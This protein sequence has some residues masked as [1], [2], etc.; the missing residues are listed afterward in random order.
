M[1][2]V[3]FYILGGAARAAPQ[4]VACRLAEKAWLMGH[5]VFIATG[6]EAMTRQLDDL[7]W[8]YR[9]DSF[10]PHGTYPGQS[11]DE[12]PI[13]IGDRDA[14]PHAEVLIN[15]SD[16][17]PPF[18]ERFVRVAELVGADEAARRAGRDRFRFYRDRGYDLHTHSL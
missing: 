8:T 12:P 17:V 4:R 3:D 14:P 2:R 11:G 1:V 5:R 15:L 13:L 6:S 7:L 9:Q 16:A 10:T 18:H